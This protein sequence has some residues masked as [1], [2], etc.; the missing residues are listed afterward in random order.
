MKSGHGV[1][2]LFGEM[3]DERSTAWRSSQSA[4]CLE[5]PS[6]SWFCHAMKIGGLPE[7]YPYAPSLNISWN[8]RRWVPASRYFKGKSFDV[9]NEERSNISIEGQTQSKPVGER[10]NYE[11]AAAYSARSSTISIPVRRKYWG[12]FR[13]RKVDSS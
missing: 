7:E 8:G 12:A 6:R 10:S 3:V 4:T 1:E 2:H 5:V 9:I 13:P 11:D